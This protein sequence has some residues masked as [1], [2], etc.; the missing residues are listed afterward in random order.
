MC[1][2]RFRKVGQGVL[3]LLVGNGFDTLDP[4]DLNF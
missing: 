4:G 2:P 3:E 1:G